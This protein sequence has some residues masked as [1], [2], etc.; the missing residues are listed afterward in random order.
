LS[1]SAARSRAISADVRQHPHLRLA[2]VVI[3]APLLVNQRC[4]LEMGNAGAQQLR[5]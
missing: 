4:R 1:A 5:T 2:G 3:D